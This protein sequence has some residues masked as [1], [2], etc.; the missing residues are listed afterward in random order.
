M[1]GEVELVAVCD[2]DAGK[3]GAFAA[4]FGVKRVYTDAE[5]M[6]SEG[7]ID[8]VDIITDVD[9]HERFVTLAARHGVDAI[10]QKPMAPNLEGCIRMARAC[11]QAGI[12]FFSHEN[13]RFQPPVRRFKALLDQGAVGEVF[14]FRLTFCSAFP[15]FDNQPFLAELEQFIL[16]DIGS[17]SLDMVRYLFG[18][19]R[20]LQCKIK[21]VNPK[22]RGE[23][24]ANVFMEMENGVHGYAE[25]SYASILEKESFPETLVLAEGTLGSIQLLHNGEVRVTTRQ[26]TTSESVPSPSYAW[27]DPAYA[28][29]HASIVATNRSLLDAFQQGHLPETHGEDNLKTM[30]LVFACYESAAKR[31]IVSIEPIL[32]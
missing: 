26:G 7:G 4:Y 25:M 23:D 3:A 31:A 14:K 5:A 19:V 12:R 13:F 9:S 17:H 20:D 32:I 2:K 22:I 10:C 15:V 21:T 29:I 24:V 28:A 11:K 18:E 30:Q 16:T 27:A 1:A 6:L 8:V